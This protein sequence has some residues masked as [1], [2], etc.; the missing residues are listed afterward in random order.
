MLRFAFPPA[1]ALARWTPVLLL[2]ILLPIACSDLRSPMEPE[3]DGAPPPTEL[4]S[5]ALTC[6]VDVRAETMHCLPTS[7]GFPGGLSPASAGDLIVGGQHQYIRMASSNMNEVS[8]NPLWEL[9]VDVTVEN[10]IGQALGT[11]DGHNPHADG[12]RVFFHSGPTTTNGSGDV[13]VHNPDGTGTFTAENQP[14]HQ[15][16]Q[17]LMP[18]ETSAIKNW[19]FRYPGTMNVFQFQVYVVAQ[20]QHRN[21]WIGISPAA[22]QVPVGNSQQLTAD[23]YSVVGAELTGAT[24]TWES[25]HPQIATVDASGLVT[26]VA[27][28]YALITATDGTRNG[29]ANVTV[30]SPSVALT[31]VAP[32][33]LLHGQSA[34]LTGQGFNDITLTANVVEVDGMPATVLSAS[35][36]T[37]EFLV[38]S[39][40]LPLRDVVVQVTVGSATDQLTASARPGS[41]VNLPVG[42][43][44]LIQNPAD[45]CLQ[46]D[47]TAGTEAYLVGVQHIS[48]LASD[49]TGVKVS[50][51]LE[52]GAI[53]A[54]VIADPASAQAPLA[55][56]AG[57]D[58][59][60]RRERDEDLMAKVRIREEQ[61]AMLPRNL[62]LLSPSQIDLAAAVA[63]DV[64]V[65]DTVELRQPFGAGGCS[66]TATL[67]IITAEVRAN[68]TRGVW[69][70]DVE[71]EVKIT[72]QHVQELSD[73]FD[74]YSYPTNVEYFGEPTDMDENGKVLILITKQLTF[75]LGFVTSADWAAQEPWPYGCINSNRAEITYLRPLSSSANMRRDF[76]VTAAHEMAHVIQVSREVT[77]GA[78]SMAGWEAEGMA[79]FAEEVVGHAV[80]GRSI[81]QNY[82][83]S[84]AYENF[85]SSTQPAWYVS[86]FTDVWRY[87]GSDPSG[88]QNAGAPEQCTFVGS[89]GVCQSTGAIYGRPWIFFRWVADQFGPTYP[90]G[91]AALMRQLTDGP[92]RGFAA[93]EN[94][95]GTPIET[96]LAQW[97]ATLYV[98][99]RIPGPAAR[100]TM[101]S[102]NLFSTFEQHALVTDGRRLVPYERA[103][104]DFVDDVS[105]RA[106]SSAY[107]RL[108]GEGRGAT[109]IRIRDAVDETLPAK[110]QI[111]VVRLQ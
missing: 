104:G 33:V 95:T 1:R 106:A 94:V 9:Q 27:E 19:R 6:T 80:T 83:S 78:P 65:G 48:S 47:G 97:A 45:L 4:I 29:S 55:A 61:R 105:V 43:Q 59:E 85:F 26:G 2:A 22:P 54:E 34:T 15:Y 69:L 109:A 44:M 84:V 46:F 70:E 103:F 50:S 68:G 31:S 17:M 93:L 28:G 76:P 23:A 82:G 56:V 11:T 25:S 53:A 12:V 91:E 92:L 66:S 52:A 110:M 64:A 75:A 16:S 7:P 96:L 89:A 60:A 102:W 90:G 100:L 58:L 88:N 67:T 5:A 8:A 35:P 71:N 101:P 20:V 77:L 38:P 73:Q 30:G 107:F 37:L 98:D 39:P 21:G 86:S 32:G 99:G 24:I 63:G 13:T 36:T 81:G 57:P 18:D 10:L 62:R 79:R 3:L 74:T 72:T 111:W 87:F 40:C 14:Y 108:S 41:F 49:L 51:V 42:E